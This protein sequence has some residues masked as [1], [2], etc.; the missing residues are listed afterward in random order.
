MER[1]SSVEAAYVPITM[2]PTKT[3]QRERRGFFHLT[4]SAPSMPNRNVATVTILQIYDVI[5]MSPVINS[6]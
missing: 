3:T 4:S 6:C 1:S 5:T 2:R